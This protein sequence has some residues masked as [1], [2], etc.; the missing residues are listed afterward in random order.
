MGFFKKTQCFFW[1]RFFYNNPDLS[2][3]DRSEFGKN[4]NTYVRLI[5]VLQVLHIL[6]YEEIFRNSLTV[7]LYT[8]SFWKL[9]YKCFDKYHIPLQQVEVSQ[10]NIAASALQWNGMILTATNGPKWNLWTTVAVGMELLFYKERYM[11]MEGMKWSM[12]TFLHLARAANFKAGFFFKGNCEVP[13]MD[14]PR[15]VFS[16]SRDPIF[17]YSRDLM[18][19]FS[20]SRDPNRVSKTP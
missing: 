13:G 18:V 17:F 12:W 7:Y 5:V 19:I 14:L 16:D 8:M 1:A 20:D 3:R 2:H 10:P 9:Q 4:I 15:F 6:W 11:F